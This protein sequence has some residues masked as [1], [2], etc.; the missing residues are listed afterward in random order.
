MIDLHVEG[1]CQECA[2]FQPCIE[3]LYADGKIIAHRSGVKPQFELSCYK[4]K[5]LKGA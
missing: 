4:L 5:K 3:R 1:Y 2:G